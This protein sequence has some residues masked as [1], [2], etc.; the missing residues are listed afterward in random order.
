MAVAARAMAAPAMAESTMLDMG[1]EEGAPPEAEPELT[2]APSVVASG[3]ALDYGTLRLARADDPQ[4]RGRLEAVGPTDD[5]RDTLLAL[6]P[7]APG[8]ERS[9]LEAALSRDDDALAFELP[10]HARPLEVSAGSFAARYQAD[11]PTPVAADGLLHGVTVLRRRGQVRRVLACV[12]ARDPSVYE[13]VTFDN[14][15]DVPLLAGPVRVFR[16]GDFVVTAPLETTAPGGTLTVG[17]GVEPGVAV[18]RNTFFEEGQAGL[19]G[20]GA[21]L[22]HRVEIE[23]RSKLARAARVEIYERVP[24]SRDDDVKVEVVRAEPKPEPYDQAERGDTVEGGLRFSF[25]LEPRGVRTCVL[26]YNITLPQKHVLVGGNRR[27]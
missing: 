24:V 21:V 15:L 23:V 22:R 16:G 14:P 25:E 2:P 27:D 1:D 4:R 10:E 20:G 19:L 26:A 11:S 13:L 18:A 17:L 7:D 12:P 3:K 8:L 6:A 9:V 5:L